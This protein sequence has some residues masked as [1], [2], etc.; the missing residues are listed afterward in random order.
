M[1]IQELNSFVKVTLL[2]KSTDLAEF[3]GAENCKVKVAVFTDTYAQ[4]IK[5]ETLAIINDKCRTRT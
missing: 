4:G 1:K 3:F 2:P 5:S